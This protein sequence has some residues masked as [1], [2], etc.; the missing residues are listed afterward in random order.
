MIFFNDTYKQILKIFICIQMEYLDSKWLF[1]PFPKGILW[2]LFVDLMFII[3][4]KSEVRF[5]FQT[6][7]V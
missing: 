1:L 2:N 3:K 6:K 7:G 4:T 5:I